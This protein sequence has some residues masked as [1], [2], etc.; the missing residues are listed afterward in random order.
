MSAAADV[1][2]LA[3]IDADAPPL[4]TLLAAEGGRRGF[5][6][7]VAAL[8]AEELGR[9]FGW[10]QTSWPEMIPAVQAGTADAILCGQGVT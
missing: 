4:F 1:L 7:A 5:E 8:L 10:V 9:P 2:R 3:C 6:P